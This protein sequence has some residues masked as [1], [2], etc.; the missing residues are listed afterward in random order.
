MKL[1]PVKK[2]RYLQLLN[3]APV[4]GDEREKMGDRS[5]R[6]F[7]RYYLRMPSF[8]MMER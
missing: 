7:Q 3:G 2:R 6:P 4:C 5:G 1:L 8:A